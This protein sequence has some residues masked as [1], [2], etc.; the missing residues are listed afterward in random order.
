MVFAF[1]FLASLAGH[2][3]WARAA[4]GLRVVGVGWLLFRYRERKR[5]A[6]GI[7]EVVA[8]AAYAMFACS[9]ADPMTAGIAM[10]GA[11]Y[12]VVRALD[13]I[14]LAQEHQAK[15]EEKA[16][17]QQLT[18]EMFLWRTPRVFQN[19]RSRRSLNRCV[20]DSTPC[21]REGRSARGSGG[22]RRSC[23]IC[24]G[25]LPLSSSRTASDSLRDAIQVSQL[26]L[27]RGCPSKCF[28]FNH[29]L[30]PLRHAVP[31]RLRPGREVFVPSRVWFPPS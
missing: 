23:V 18:A 21:V 17:E 30:E 31:V 25:D 29:S 3:F 13:N 24:D 2:S 19:R 15:E 12:V 22:G 16:A 11:V 14:K 8:A 20:A 1:A 5:E 7:T 6:F 9:A 28:S 26:V 4:A 27:M 10:L